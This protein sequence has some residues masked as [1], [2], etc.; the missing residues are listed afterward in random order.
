MDKKIRK[1]SLKDFVKDSSSNIRLNS[2]RHP[3]DLNL[4]GTKIHK[5][6]YEPNI[7]VVRNKNKSHLNRIEKPS[8]SQKN[9]QNKSKQRLMQ[10]TGVFSE[11]V[12][13]TITSPIDKKAEVKKSGK[14]TNLHISTSE[15]TYQE[16]GKKKRM[17][18]F[19]ELVEYQSSSD[20][21]MEERHSFVPHHWN[22]QN[23]MKFDNELLAIFENISNTKTMV[24]QMPSSLPFEMNPNVSKTNEIVDRCLTDFPQGKIG[25]MLIRKSGKIE[26]IFGNIKYDLISQLELCYETLVS[27]NIE[28][29]RS[30]V[31]K[32]VD[33]ECILVPNWS[34]LMQAN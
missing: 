3:R 30:L 7:N 4:G 27:L 20:S 32:K 11:G 18:L 6:K 26:V 29:K 28:L 22:I 8:L 34:R 15:K 21:E 13:P 12:G 14:K 5:K 25:K 16:L 17:D 31:L 19:N 1:L 23:E 10:S 24:W 9:A 33:N 2:I